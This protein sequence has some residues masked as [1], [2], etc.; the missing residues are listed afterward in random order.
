M[1]N[2]FVEEG[3]GRGAFTAWSRPS[4]FLC[5]ESRAREIALSV[6]CLFCRCPRL[7]NVAEYEEGGIIYFEAE[8]L[9][10]KRRRQFGL[11]VFL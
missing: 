7:T 5:A 2:K 6:G 8:C 1:T 11:E 9:A 3:D 10:C 4:G